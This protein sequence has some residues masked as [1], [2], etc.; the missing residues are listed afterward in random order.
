MTQPVTG[1]TAAILSPILWGFAPI[2]FK[3]LMSYPLMEVMAQ[4][5]LWAGILFVLVL[6]C[7]AGLRAVSRPYVTEERNRYFDVLC[8]PSGIKLVGL[9]FRCLYKSNCPLGTRVFY[10]PTPCNSDEY[11]VI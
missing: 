10:L 9:P 8:C 1:M 5:A 2:Y 11:F 7:C 4:R 6:F 3:L